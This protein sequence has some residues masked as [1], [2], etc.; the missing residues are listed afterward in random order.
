MGAGKSSNFET[1]GWAKTGGERKPMSLTS[2]LRISGAE[3]EC[4][5]CQPNKLL[6]DLC[7][8]GELKD[9]AVGV[10]RSEMGC[11]LLRGGGCCRVAL[12][13]EEMEPSSSR[14]PYAE[15]LNSST[16]VAWRARGGCLVDPFK[17]G[18]GW[19]V[20]KLELVVDW[21]KGLMKAGMC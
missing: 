8:T 12:A 1:E 15:G 18:E 21:K 14:T 7:F 10:P 20:V 2:R 6:E 17:D 4:I 19:L 13:S 16:M 9:V 3:M 11:G 5:E